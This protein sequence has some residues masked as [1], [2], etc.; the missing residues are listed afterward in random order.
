MKKVL[1][2]LVILLIFPIFSCSSSN[3][4]NDSD[5]IPDADSDGEKLD[6]NPVNER[7]IETLRTFRKS[8]MTIS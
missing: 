6:F 4:S 7:K 8:E 3:S 5:M 1:N 2:L